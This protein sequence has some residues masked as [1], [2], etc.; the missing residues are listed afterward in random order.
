MNCW[1]VLL[2]L[3]FSIK[4]L[5]T[6][7]SRAICSL[8]SHHLWVRHAVHYIILL[9]MWVRH[10]VRNVGPSHLGFPFA[11]GLP[12]SSLCNR[13]FQSYQKPRRHY[14][15]YQLSELTTYL[16]RTT[17]ILSTVGVDIPVDYSFQS[18]QNL[19]NSRS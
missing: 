19:V 13:S 17:K 18:Y 16:F 6:V 15:S 3:L 1:R 2:K 9:H 11:V 8:H 10:T 7:V 5:T 14:A 4:C 12:P